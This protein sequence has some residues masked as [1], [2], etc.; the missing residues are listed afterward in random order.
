MKKL[1]YVKDEGMNKKRWLRGGVAICLSAAVLSGC[2]TGQD[3]QG[4]QKDL[5]N[6][7]KVMYSGSE[8]YF[9]QEFGMLFSAVYPNI[10]LEVVNTLSL[11]NTLLD[12]YNQDMNKALDAFIEQEQ[13][14]VVLLDPTTITPLIENG[15]L[16]NLDTYVAE[17]SYNVGG[18]NPGLHDYMK[19]I[20]GG[21]V[22]AIPS[23]F[24]SQA[25]FYNKDLF[26]QYGVPYPTDQMTWDEI[27]A[28]ANHFPT[29][30]APSDRIYGLEMSWSK[31]LTEVV[32]VLATAEGLNY[33]NSD[34]M[35]M[36]IDT[37]AWESIVE[38][39]NQV[40]TSDAI[41]YYDY[42]YSG[43]Y[44]ASSESSLG[45]PFLE[46]RL[47][48]KLESNY[49]IDTIEIAQN[50]AQDPE[51]I[52]Q[53]WDM[54]TAPVGLQNPDSTGYS[55]FYN[56]FAINAAS[57]NKEAAWTFISYI[58][59]D[60]FARVQSKQSYGNIP[61][62]AQYFDKG[63]GRNYA[64]FYKLKP[65]N[66]VPAYHQVPQRFVYEFPSMLQQEFASISDGQLTIEH[67]LSELQIKGNE[68]LATE[69]MSQEELKLY[70][71]EQQ[72]VLG[73]GV[74]TR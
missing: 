52:V 56:L 32:N 50:N 33:F 10:E 69:I 65:I 73:P 43:D 2:A 6:S 55:M 12:Q 5:A 27:V 68:L 3:K 22:Y 20:G 59:G 70:L 8:D 35:Q 74:I 49:Y 72:D 58:T 66:N 7:L 31:E 18:F 4:S 11:E 25:L 34:T 60:E 29:D 71:Q 67:A 41:F 39:S 38:Q 9:Y 19:D 26:D 63:D 23:T 54:V 47:A 40:L 48:M 61:L 15:K 13:P 1:R 42:I 44:E 37:P 21:Q 14:D 45:D 16:Y 17:E 62:R 51:D 36:S 57:T 30:G 53:Q 64:A 24:R 28:L 46:G